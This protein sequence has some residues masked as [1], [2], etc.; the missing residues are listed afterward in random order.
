MTNRVSVII[1]TFNRAL[2]LPQAIDSVIAQTVGD[3]EI[4]IVD[5]ASTDDTAAV[6]ARHARD[7]RIHY[8][9]NERNMGI[10]RTRN[11]GI[12]ACSAPFIAFLDSDDVWIDRDKLARQ[13]D[14]IERTPGCVLIGTDASVI[15]RSGRVTGAIR[16][17]ARDR[18]IRATMF[19]KNQF[20]MSSVL[21]RRSALD[22][23]GLFDEDFP[24]VMIDYELW[25][26]VARLHR[27]ANLRQRMTGYR[28]HGGNIS[29][30]SHR[31]TLDGL[32]IVHSQ[33]GNDFPLAWILHL[34]MWR[35]RIALARGAD[36]SVARRVL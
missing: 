36:T 15:D 32:R 26:R 25:L 1:P 16:N 27:V 4:I 23:V 22:E 6:V 34:R 20:V 2:F 7:H 9:R 21:I 5:D 33:Y 14:A 24:P 18:S 8:L 29:R 35:E 13:L 12:G 31:S 3:L 19:I 10:A 11:R 30:N 28:V 17:L